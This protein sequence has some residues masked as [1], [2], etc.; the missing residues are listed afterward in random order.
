LNLLEV[1]LVLLQIEPLPVQEMLFVQAFLLSPVVAAA[2]G[3]TV[4]N[5]Q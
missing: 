5:T 4:S 1:C 2:A 3:R